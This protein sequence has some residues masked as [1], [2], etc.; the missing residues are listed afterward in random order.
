MVM[1]VNRIDDYKKFRQ[2]DDKFDSHA[3]GVIWR[4]MHCAIERICGFVQSY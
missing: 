4:D 1:G 3:A 2:I